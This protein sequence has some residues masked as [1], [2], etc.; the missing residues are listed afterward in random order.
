MNNHGS[1]TPTDSQNT[2]NQVV[3]EF[4]KEQRRRRWE[5]WF[6]RLIILLMLAFFIYEAAWDSD[7]KTSGNKPH[8]GM[9]D[10]NGTID[11]QDANAE[12]FEKSLDSAYK[13]TGLKALVIRINSPGGSPVQA[14]YM[15]NALKTYRKNYP[16]IK[17]YAVCVDICASAAYYVASAADQIYADESSMVGSIG[18]IYNGFGFVDA[19]QK[20]GVSRRMQTAGAN[21]GFLDPFSPEVAEQQQ[22]LQEMLNEVH[23]QF[24]N[25]VKQGRGNRL[26]IDAQTFSGLIWTG[27]QAKERGLIDGFA[28]AS[29]LIKNVI[30][31]D[32]V[33]DYTNKQSVLEKVARNMGTEMANRL[34]LAFGLKSGIRA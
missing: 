1:D 21:K 33:I 12:N 32:Q 14:D 29:G 13:N 2:L 15:Y 24:I 31:I 26:K 16:D 10:L 8:V 19:M 30:K 27:T 11:A 28:G 3:L 6:F 5:R 18:V 9:I 25:K 22:Y 4:M 34:P 7:D 23:T 17:I 20:L